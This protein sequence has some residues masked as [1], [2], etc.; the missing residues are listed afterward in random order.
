VGDLSL[1]AFSISLLLHLFLAGFLLDPGLVVVLAV[2][3]PQALSYPHP[4]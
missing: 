1:F 2:S 3:V 4:S